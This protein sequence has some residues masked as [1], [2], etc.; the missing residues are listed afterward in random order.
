MQLKAER[1]DVRIYEVTADDKARLAR[2][3]SPK[4][5]GIQRRIYNLRWKVKDGKLTVTNEEFNWFRTQFEKLG[6]DGGWQHRVPYEMRVDIAF[7]L[8]RPMPVKH[9]HQDGLF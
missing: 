1:R 9:A 8:G 7:E 4:G 6:M 2:Q 5:G 3:D